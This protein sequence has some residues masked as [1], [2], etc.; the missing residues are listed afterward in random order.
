VLFRSHKSGL[1]KVAAALLERETIDGDEV[2]RLVD[3]GFGGPVHPEMDVPHFGHA[4]PNGQADP[5]AT[6]AAG[7]TS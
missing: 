1:D 4:A 5:D 7:R 3:D 6:P 2:R